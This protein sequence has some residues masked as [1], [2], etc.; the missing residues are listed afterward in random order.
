M[1]REVLDQIKE[2]PLLARSPDHCLQA[3]RESEN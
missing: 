3:G 1:D 2:L